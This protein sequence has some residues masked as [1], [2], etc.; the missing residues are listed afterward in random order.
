MNFNFSLYQ[1]INKDIVLKNL[2][3]S[4]YL[5]IKNIQLFSIF[6]YI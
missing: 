5:L 3:I 2:F 4:S 1:L 6:H